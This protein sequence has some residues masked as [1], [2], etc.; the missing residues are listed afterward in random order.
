[1]FADFYLGMCFIGFLG[2]VFAVL[3][4]IADKLEER[5]R[6]KYFVG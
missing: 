3:G 2:L 4:Y 6:E 5:D 1:M